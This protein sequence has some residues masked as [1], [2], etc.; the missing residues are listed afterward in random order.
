MTKGGEDLFGYP[1]TIVFPEFPEYGKGSTYT[2]DPAVFGGSYDSVM[3]YS[4][5]EEVISDLEFMLLQ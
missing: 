5:Y 4:E 2:S 1:L 3:L